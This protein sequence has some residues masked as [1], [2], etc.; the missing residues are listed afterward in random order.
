MSDVQVGDAI[1]LWQESEMIGPDGDE[2]ADGAEG[3]E[4]PNPQRLLTEGIDPQL[5]TAL[6]ILRAQALRYDEVRHARL[7]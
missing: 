2:L 7:N 1:T 3:E 5:E 4:R 6:L